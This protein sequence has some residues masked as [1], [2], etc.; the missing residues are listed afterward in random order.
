[1]IKVPNAA[2][3]FTP[4]KPALSHVEGSERSAS[5]TAVSG[6]NMAG[7]KAARLADT[8]A[9]Q[10]AGTKRVWVL[11]PSGD[12]EPVPV[13]IGISDGNFTE[14]LGGELKEGDA[15]IIGIETPRGARKQEALPP[16]FGSGQRRPSSRDRGL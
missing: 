15:V 2:L 10:L 14:L 16:G 6:G 7:K 9:G 13:Q 8:S 11:G 1:V 4:P 12:P 3:R 5:G